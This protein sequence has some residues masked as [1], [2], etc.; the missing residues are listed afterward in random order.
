[1]YA[2]QTLPT[3]DLK[4]YNNTATTRDGYSSLAD[5]QRRAEVMSMTQPWIDAGYTVDIVAGF[6]RDIVKSTA[7]AHLTKPVSTDEPLGRDVGAVPG[8]LYRILSD[9]M[10][11]PIMGNPA[12]QKFYN[13]FLGD[14]TFQNVAFGVSSTTAANKG[15]T[16]NLRFDLCSGAVH[17]DITN[18]KSYYA[19]M[20]EYFVI[21]AG[22]TNQAMI[23]P[24]SGAATFY[25]TLAEAVAACPDGGTVKLCN[26]V[27]STAAVV[28][29]KKSV[30]IDTNGFAFG[31][32]VV[33]GKN[34]TMTTAAS[35]PDIEKYLGT[36]RRTFTVKYHKPGMAI[37]LR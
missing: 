24:A 14:S 15:T 21:G 3:A 33:P 32:T 7:T 6:D 17:T 9:Y 4:L 23:Q 8:D 12:D 22:Q 29:A 26:D 37:L 13:A 25:A 35:T 10:I 28:V 36:V 1:M 34:C 30:T 19:L 27:A 5:W 18:L 11:H 20:S 16:V 31:G 2:F